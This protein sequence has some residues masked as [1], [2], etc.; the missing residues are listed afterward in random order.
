MKQA[1]KLLAHQGHREIA[2]LS[3]PSVTWTNKQ[4]QAAISEVTNDPGIR[5]VIIPT[6]K[7]SLESGQAIVDQMIRSGVT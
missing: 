6:E 3:G 7:P 4:R 1:V 5:L 2:Y